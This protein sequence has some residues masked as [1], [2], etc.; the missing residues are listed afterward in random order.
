MSPPTAYLSLFLQ[1]PL[2]FQAQAPAVFEFNP[3][4]ASLNPSHAPSSADI[5]EFLCTSPTS[6]ACPPPVSDF[7]IIVFV[8]PAMPSCSA[9]S[10]SKPGSPP[11]TPFCHQACH[12]CHH[13]N[14]S[15]KSRKSIF[16]ATGSLDADPLVSGASTVYKSLGIAISALPFPRVSKTHSSPPFHFTQL[17]CYDRS[18][19]RKAIRILSHTKSRKSAATHTRNHTACLTDASSFS[20]PIP[21]AFLSSH[22]GH[23]TLS[24]SELAESCESISIVP[25]P[26]LECWTTSFH[27]SFLLTRRHLNKSSGP[28]K[29]NK[30]PFLS[31][32]RCPRVAHNSLERIPFR[33]HTDRPDRVDFIRVRDNFGP[34]LASSPVVQVP[35]THGYCTWPQWLELQDFCS[36][37]SLFVPHWHTRPGRPESGR[38][39][40]PRLPNNTHTLPVTCKTFRQLRRC[41]SHVLF[42]ISV[43]PTLLIPI[44]IT[45]AIS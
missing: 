34:C 17:R 36:R 28:Y 30:F 27:P 7:F 2:Q 15:L 1:S 22:P 3:S 14:M 12:H 18:N 45:G 44:F 32:P 16:C 38:V 26:L 41:Y 6:C 37:R 24:P 31:K 8:T 20:H 33:T 43:F 10:P 29:S 19:S 11:H 25:I 35:T 42:L 21:S 4:D 40:L 13:R 5:S 39:E 23:L 9:T